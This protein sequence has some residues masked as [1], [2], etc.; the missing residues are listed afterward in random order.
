[1]VVLLLAGLGLY[2]LLSGDDG[3]GTGTA[4]QPRSTPTTST[5]TPADEPTAAGMEDFIRDYVTAVGEDPS[6]SWKMLTP[7]FQRESGGFENYRRFWEDASNGRVLR[8]TADPKD[9]SVSYVVRFDGFDNP[10]GPTVLDLVYDD[11]TYR[12]NGERTKGFVPAD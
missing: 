4:Q 8:I 1:M 12:I 6:R 11:G 7:K 10:P 9:L 5:S 3:G 2:A